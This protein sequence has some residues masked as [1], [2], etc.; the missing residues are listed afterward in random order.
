MANGI[1]IGGP[2]TFLDVELSVVKGADEAPQSLLT[3]ETAMKLEA[4]LTMSNVVFYPVF[5]SSSFWNT[6]LTK[7]AVEMGSH[8]YDHIFDNI[9]MAMGNAWNEKYKAGV[10]IGAFDPQLAMIGGLIKNS[11][12]SPYI[13]DGWM[14]A[15]FSMAADAPYYH[16][17]YEQN[18]FEQYHHAREEVA[19]FL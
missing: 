6:T 14:Y 18:T 4:N 1:V 5:K 15:G 7:S 8:M 16:Q 17:L 11:T 19:Q 9:T 2:H 3:F 12:M 13:A 10:P